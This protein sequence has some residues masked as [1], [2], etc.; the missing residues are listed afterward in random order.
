MVKCA[1]HTIKPELFHLHNLGLLSNMDTSILMFFL[2]VSVLT[3]NQGKFLRNHQSHQV[4]HLQSTAHCGHHISE[5]LIHAHHVR[6]PP[7]RQETLT[8]THPGAF[9]SGAQRAMG[10]PLHCM[11][12]LT[13]AHKELLGAQSSPKRRTHS[14]ILEFLFSLWESNLRGQLLQSVLQ[15][16]CL[17]LNPDPTCYS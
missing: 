17:N 3:L 4:P 8:H 13:S 16:D 15:L 12:A 6:A 5:Y 10:G 9:W 14:Q 7:G 2:E 11:R 1:H